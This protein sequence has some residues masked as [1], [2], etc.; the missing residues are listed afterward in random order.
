MIQATICYMELTCNTC[1]NTFTAKRSDA[2]YCS[3][4]CRTQASRDRNQPDRPRAKR[5]PLPDQFFTKIYDLGKTSYALEA[6]A[7]DDRMPRYAK[8]L[9]DIHRA[10]L[11]SHIERLQKVLEKLN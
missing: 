8:D 2:K 6:L 9:G 11:Q 3:P 4:R 7:D 10:Q 5:R 1:D